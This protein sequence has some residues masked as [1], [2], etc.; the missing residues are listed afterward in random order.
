MT[1]GEKIMFLMGKALES[2]KKRAR[3]IEKEKDEE[4]KIRMLN[5]LL[6]DQQKYGDMLKTIEKELK[7]MEKEP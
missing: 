2:F 5:K 7:K 4:A 3:I 1:E 6:G